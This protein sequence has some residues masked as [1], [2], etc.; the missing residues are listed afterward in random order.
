[1]TKPEPEELSP[2]DPPDLGE[3]VAD[4]PDPAFGEID[5]DEAETPEPDE[6][7]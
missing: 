5:D 4:E 2:F 3:E 6:P 1:M 7:D